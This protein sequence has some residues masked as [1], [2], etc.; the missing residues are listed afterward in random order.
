MTD[1]YRDAAREDEVS[2]G[3]TFDEAIVM[4]MLR[5]VYDR[6]IDIGREIDAGLFHELH[7]VFDKAAAEGT[8]VHAP[9][10]AGY[11]F[12]QE[13]KTNNGVFAAF[14]THRFQR[15]VAGQLFDG[16]GKL[17][18]FEQFR[19]DTQS[20]VSH[21]KDAWLRTE[22]DTA[23]KR[24]RRGAQMRRFV[25]QSDVLPNLEWLPSTALNPRESHMPFYHHVWP[26][27][28]PFWQKHK[29]GDEWGCQCDW[30]A[31]DAPV[32]DNT[33]LDP[34]QAAP[35]RGLRS[36]PARD[37]RLFSDDHPYF[38]DKCRGCVFNISPPGL[39]Y[40]KT[41]DC[42]RCKA[43]TD[44]VRAAR[45]EQ[46][47]RLAERAREVRQLIVGEFGYDALIP[48]PAG[49]SGGTGKLRL[50]PA[51]LRNCLRVHTHSKTE[52]SK[53]I[54][55]VALQHPE[56]L[57]HDDRKPLGA[58]KDMSDP[59]DA[60]NVARKRA[61]G[62]VAYNYYEFDWDGKIWIL[63]FE[64]MEEGYEQPYFIARKK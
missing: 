61:R 17:K 20:I 33:G 45:A 34:R 12:L 19:A 63:G 37:G 57:R 1:L 22:Y 15:D 5:T 56:L 24:A 4:E 26:I 49:K 6:R 29:P 14:K 32:T 11:D 44:A 62:V 2:A 28:D 41:K 59:V 36:D 54:L 43:V 9:H 16:E 7:R 13:L 53:Q 39:F 23:I 48:L 55:F 58:T 52:Q 42:Y 21:H 18:S 3:F 51:G 10:D 64:E 40:N 60:A 30:E 46:R 47:K 38:P 8:G 35:S 25:A 31:T 27:G 50:T